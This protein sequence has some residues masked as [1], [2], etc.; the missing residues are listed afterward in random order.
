VVAVLAALLGGPT[1]ASAAAP[2]RVALN[3]TADPARSQTVTWR[4]PDGAGGSLQLRA[5]D[6]RAIRSATPDESELLRGAR[7][8]AVTLTGLRPDTTYGYRVGHDGA[9]SPWHAFRTATD[10][11]RAPW[12]WLYLGDA[13]EELDTWARWVRPAF[14]AVPDARLVMH[15]GDLVNAPNEDREWG[16]W[17]GGQR[18]TIERINVFSVPGNHEYVGTTDRLPFVDADAS[19]RTFRTHFRFPRNGVPGF[20]DTNYVF[21]HQGVRFIGLNT[22]DNLGYDP[23]PQQ[24]AWLDRTIAESTQRWTVV[25]FHIPVFSS[26]DQHHSQ[27]AR[28]RRS[29][30]EILERRDVD[31]V[32]QGHTHAYGR[33]FVN[34][35]PDG[36]QYVVSVSSPKYYDLGTPPGADWIA[37]GATARAIV[38]Q[39]STAQEICVGPDRLGLRATIIGKGPGTTTDKPVGAVLDAFTI[40]KDGGRKRVEDGFSCDEPRP[41]TA[42][43]P[44]GG[45]AGCLGRPAIVDVATRGRHDRIR[46]EVPLA[47]AGGAVRVERSTGGGWRTVVRGRADAHGRV[48]VGVPASARRVAARTR[49]RVVAGTGRSSAAG[50]DRAV[51]ITGMARRGERVTVAGRGAARAPARIEVRRGCGAWRSVARVRSTRAGAVRRTVDVPRGSA[52]RLVV[53]GARSLPRTAR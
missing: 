51:R 23:S 27:A 9:W 12:R 17:F 16:Q 39:T 33:G 52:V 22:G 13:Q 5:A 32:L 34:G 53:A 10:G 21:D 48:D 38:G 30:L 47:R 18:G 15:V 26:A 40:R 49:Y 3:P 37:N 46:A 45:V 24:A 6:G 35:H 41:P 14:D 43:E 29:W 11:L 42:T 4:A 36:P 2:D 7:H 1:A 31:L 8:H 25:F 28:V 19:A 44:G 50:R 20:S